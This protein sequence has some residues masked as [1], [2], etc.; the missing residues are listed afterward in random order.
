MA[1]Y[2]CRHCGASPLEE[3]NCHSKWIPSDCVS[4]TAHKPPIGL[5]PMEVVRVLRLQEI[6]EAIGRYLADGQKIPKE[7][8]DEFIVLNGRV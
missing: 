1:H 2:D 6:H 7:W 4:T 3:C 8:L 5:R